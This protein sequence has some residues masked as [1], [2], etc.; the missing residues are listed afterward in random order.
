M[1]V[2]FILQAY[3]TD[4]HVCAAFYFSRCYVRY[5]HYLPVA[6]VRHDRKFCGNAG[7]SAAAI[8]DRSRL[9]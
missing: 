4:R 5:D 1:S 3:G 2:G 8:P 9:V 6:F 7:L